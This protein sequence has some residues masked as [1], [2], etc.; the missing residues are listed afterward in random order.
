MDLAKIAK[1]YNARIQELYVEGFEIK[2]EESAGGLT[3]YILVK[4]PETKKSKPDKALNV[5]ID[6]IKS[7]YNGSL[8]IE[9]LIDELNDN[10]FTVRRNIGSFC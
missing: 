10:N 9:Q 6:G 3:K 8:T 2:V 7:K 5:L 1:R 4:E